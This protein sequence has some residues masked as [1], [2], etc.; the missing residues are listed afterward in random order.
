M[1]TCN[2][3]KSTENGIIKEGTTLNYNFLA[4]VTCLAEF[5]NLE[6]GIFDYRIRKT[7]SDIC[8]RS[9]FLLSLLYTGVHKYGTA[10]T[11]VYRL[12]GHQGNFTELFY[13]HAHCVG[14]VIEEGTTTGR[15]GFVKLDTYNS[16]VLHAEALHI[17]TAD[18]QQELNARYKEVCSAEV[19]NGF[20]LTGIYTKSCLEKGFTV[21]GRNSACNINIFRKLSIQILKN[22]NCKLN[23]ISLIM[24]IEIPDNA[25]VFVYQTSLSCC[26]TGIKAKENRTVSFFQIAAFSLLF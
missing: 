15:A 21:T 17:L 19:S 1:N 8:Y 2:F 7:S 20:N 9:T 11:K 14:K 6:Q 26:R 23:R 25:A 22:L 13:V 5:D 10:G 16:A 4:Y 18:V 24:S 3:F 12:L